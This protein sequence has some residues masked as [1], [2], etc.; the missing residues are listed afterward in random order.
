[1]SVERVAWDAASRRT[2]PLLSRIP[3]AHVLLAGLMG[4]FAARTGQE[5][6]AA[7][8]TP[9]LLAP[10]LACPIAAHLVLQRNNAGLSHV[11]ATSPVRKRT[12]FQVNEP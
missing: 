6:A 10:A 1:M 5:L 11:L 3:A 12:I 8:S 9:Y 2:R 4:I 7:L